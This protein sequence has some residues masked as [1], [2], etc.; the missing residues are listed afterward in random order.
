MVGGAN[1][2]N[3][4]V[5]SSLRGGAFLVMVFNSKCF[6]E[7]TAIILVEGVLFLPFAI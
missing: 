4:Y 2:V 7:S 3:I 1:S 5:V 6:V